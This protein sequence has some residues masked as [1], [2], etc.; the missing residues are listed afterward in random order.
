MIREECQLHLPT[1]VAVATAVTTGVVVV[2]KSVVKVHGQVNSP[3]VHALDTLKLSAALPIVVFTD[4]MFVFTGNIGA[5][6]PPNGPSCCC[7]LKM[8]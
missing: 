3:R 2:L 1:A 6:S 5:C 4:P 8:N 7:L